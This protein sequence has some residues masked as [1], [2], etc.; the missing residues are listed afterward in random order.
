MKTRITQIGNSQGVRI[1]KMMLE[2]AQISGEV[3]L[4]ITESGILIRNIK[5]PRS[6]WDT[7]FEQFADSDDQST[8]NPE[9]SKFGKENWQ[10]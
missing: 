4:E 5:K 9:T 6:D 7:L 10:W 3:K 1:P 2:E 8:E